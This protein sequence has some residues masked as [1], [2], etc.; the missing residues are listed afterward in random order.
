M[1]ITDGWEISLLRGSCCILYL[2]VLSVYILHQEIWKSFYKS[3]TFEKKI[4]KILNFRSN[5]PGDVIPLK[6]RSDGYAWELLQ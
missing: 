5:K 4:E 3:G 1:M 6:N 2:A